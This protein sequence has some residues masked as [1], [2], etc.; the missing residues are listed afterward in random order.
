MYPL[1]RLQG[2]DLKDIDL[3]IQWK[4]T[5]DP[6]VLWQRFRC[7]ACDRDMQ[8]T[9]LLFIETKD[10]DLVEPLGGRKQKAPEAGGKNGPKSKWAK[11]VK[12][13]PRVLDADGAREGEFWKA[14]KEVYHE[15][16][17]DEK[18]LELNQVLDDIINAE[19]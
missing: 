16:I 4:V 6:C 15:P 8:A 3:I 17:S 10:L 14:R 11:K 9:A 18:K 19:G 5:C 7:G 12:P 13:V 2:I 1:T